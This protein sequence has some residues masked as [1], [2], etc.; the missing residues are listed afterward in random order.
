MG[1]QKLSVARQ[2]T[3]SSA[4]LLKCVFWKNQRSLRKTLERSAGEAER[5]IRAIGN[6]VTDPVLS[7]PF[8]DGRVIDTKHDMVARAGCGGPDVRFPSTKDRAH[9]LHARGL[10]QDKCA[11]AARR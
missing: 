10:R 9:T 2:R 8:A 5:K 3:C 11:V 6:G 1:D 7:G 4:V